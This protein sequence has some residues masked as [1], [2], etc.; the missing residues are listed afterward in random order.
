M[1]TKTTEELKESI[2]NKELGEIR[3]NLAGSDLFPIFL[4]CCNKAFLPSF[5]AGNRGSITDALPDRL[6]GDLIEVLVRKGIV[7]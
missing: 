3:S 6:W 1:F 2:G 7:R 4:K 5:N